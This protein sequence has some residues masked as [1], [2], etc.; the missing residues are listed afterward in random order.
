VSLSISF[1]GKTAALAAALVFV[2]GCATPGKLEVTSQGTSSSLATPSLT[3]DRALSN[4]RLSFISIFPLENLSGFAAPLKEI[5]E[6]LIQDL[7][8]K[9]FRVL[10]EKLLEEFMARQRVRYVGGIDGA[11][12]QALGEETGVG[13][14]LITSLE[15][16]DEKYPPKI[17]LTA[18][19]V[20]ADDSPVILWMDS[21]GLSGDDSPGLLEL[22]LIEDPKE[23][24]AKAP[25]SLFGSLKPT[26]SQIQD[27]GVAARQRRKFRPK[28]FFHSPVMDPEE[29]Y[30]VAVLPFFNWSDRKYA[31][32]IMALHFVRELSKLR[33]FRVLELGV[34]RQEL[35]K[36]RIIMDDGISLDQA[37]VIL[38]SLDANLA[39][40]GKVIDYQDAQGPEGTPVVDFSLFVIGKKGLEVMWASKSY[41]KGSDGVFFYDWGRVRTANAMA[42]EMVRT[43]SAM[44]GSE[45]RKGKK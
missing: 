12:A 7:K 4:E 42:S 18:R 31:N 3:A 23:L 45:F 35:L 26:L 44:M 28:Y 10:D 8:N 22:G 39:F 19:L 2:F 33:N 11:N 38:A 34:I 40:T 14:V 5:R 21:I 36:F 25:E 16:Y 27:E 15:L 1:S 37:N 24:L 6:S 43:V 20:S 41:N 9:G 32:E 30:V 29:K 13:A 17:A